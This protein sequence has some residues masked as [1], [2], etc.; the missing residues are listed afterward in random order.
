MLS[1]NGSNEVMAVAGS[2]GSNTRVIIW[3]YHGYADQFWYLE[4]AGGNTYRYHPAHNTG[5]CLDVPG[6]DTSTRR[7]LVVWTCNGGRNQV[8]GHRANDSISPVIN[9]GKCLDVHTHNSGERVW[10]WPCNGTAA[11]RWSFV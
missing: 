5:L 7:T 3:P 6:S 9:V 2:G 11:Q 8:F 10:L 1:A 4:P